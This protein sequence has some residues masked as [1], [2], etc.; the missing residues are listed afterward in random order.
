MVATLLRNKLYIP[1]ET[2]SCKPRKFHRKNLDFTMKY[3]TSFPKRKKAVILLSNMYPHK[4]ITRLLD[5]TKMTQ[6]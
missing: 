5:K 2:V 1:E 4:I 3:V 6:F